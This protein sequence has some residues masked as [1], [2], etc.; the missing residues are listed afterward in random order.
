M[1]F[2]VEKWRALLGRAFRFTWNFCVGVS[3]LV[4]MDQLIFCMILTGETSR[5]ILKQISVFFLFLG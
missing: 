4:T 5:D 3:T 2:S 1:I